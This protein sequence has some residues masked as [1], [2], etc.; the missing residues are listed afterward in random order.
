MNN[1][2][3]FCLIDFFFYFLARIPL[4]LFNT[5]IFQFLSKRQ[6]LR[7]R[8]HKSNN[9]EQKFI[10]LERYG[11]PRSL[12]PEDIR[13]GNLKFDYEDWL[14]K[15]CKADVADAK[16]SSVGFQEEKV[17][18]MKIKSSFDNV[19][20]KNVIGYFGCRC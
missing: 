7:Y 16:F 9:Q 13:G 8:I 1:E 20:C 15:Q 6:R 5:V 2:A 12:I 11:I 19:Q 4:W 18:W 14:M 3:Y 17:Y 10:S